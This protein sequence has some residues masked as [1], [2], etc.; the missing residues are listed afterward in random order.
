MTYAG[1]A[2]AIL[3]FL[4]SVF[5]NVQYLN[6]S[7]TCIFFLAPILLFLNQDSFLLKNLTPRNRYFPIIL[8][9]SVFLTFYA[10]Y[11]ILVQSILAKYGLVPSPDHYLSS[12]TLWV[13][14]FY[15]L[16]TTPSHFYFN[17][18]MWTFSRQSDLM[19]YLILP[20]N[21]FGI[22]LAE[23]SSVQMLG[24]LGVIG[25]VVHFVYKSEIQKRGKEMI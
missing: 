25:G 6:G 11:K 21:L 20:L 13:N 22:F 15:L 19:W 17:Q 12:F 8:S 9:T 1:N 16:C 2:S 10:I 5:L 24:V 23:F 4:L 14:W 18:F 7:I 3:A